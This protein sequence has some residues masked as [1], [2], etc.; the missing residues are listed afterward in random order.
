M[1]ILGIK[2]AA[3]RLRDLE[4]AS[5][6]RIA[7]LEEQLVSV[8][9][10]AAR[11]ARLAEDRTSDLEDKLAREVGWTVLGDNALAAS[12]QKDRKSVV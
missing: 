8:R 5:S 1:S 10:Y 3:D 11:Q 2:T 6:Q 7:A 9:D 12:M 4:A